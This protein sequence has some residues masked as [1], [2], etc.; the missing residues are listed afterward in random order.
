MSGAA[1]GITSSLVMITLASLVG[2]G[3]FV[4]ASYSK[5][6]RDHNTD[7]VLARIHENYGNNLDVVRGLFVVTCSPLI[8]AYF[9]LSAINQLV[10][11]IGIN[12]CAQPSCQVS[13]SD[14]SAGVVTVR[15]KKQ[16]TSMRTWDRAKVF[17]Y[18]IYWGVAYMVMQVLVANLTVVFL[19]W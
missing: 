8:V 19:S 3:I 6:E 10:R 9:C 1:A 18:A 7:V 4:S 15:A 5:Q 16:I 12:P 17:T 14:E 13:D 11:R 2:A